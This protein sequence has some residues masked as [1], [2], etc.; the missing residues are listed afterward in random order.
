LICI[1]A[2][3]N[4]NIIGFENSKEG[5]KAI[6]QVT[7]NIFYIC[8][9]TDYLK[10]LE[11]IK[12]QCPRKFGMHPTNLNH[13]GRKK[14]KPLRLACAMAGSLALVIALWSLKSGWQI[15]SERNMASL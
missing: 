9:E 10:V 11:H 4:E 1:D 7:S 12:T 6:S 13:M 14:L 2:G 5:L 15:S 8:E 3:N